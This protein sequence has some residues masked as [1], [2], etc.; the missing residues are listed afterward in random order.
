MAIVESKRGRD[1]ARELFA[2]IV[3][4]DH[5]SWVWIVAVEELAQLD[6]R[7]GRPGD[8]IVLLRRALEE[9]PDDQGLSVALAFLDRAHRG[10]SRATLEAL[11]SRPALASARVAYS[12][13]EG[14]EAFAAALE[15]LVV[16]HLPNLDE[17]LY[18]TD[19]E[20]R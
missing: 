18:W 15:A 10:R 6:A 7:A 5:R 3:D 1:E 17:A 19:E 12:D 4:S 9:Y 2:G 8:A 11:E 16:Q 13:W 14:M 20:R